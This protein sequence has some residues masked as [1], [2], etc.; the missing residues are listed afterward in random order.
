MLFI[1]IIKNKYNFCKKKIFYKTFFKKNIKNFYKIIYIIIK[2][3]FNK[4]KKNKFDKNKNKYFFKKILI[5]I[6]LLW[7]ISGFFIVKETE[8]A[9]ILRLGKFY[10]INCSGL[11][12]K[13]TFIDTVIIANIKSL[14][15]IKISD[16]ILTYD[17]NLI[18]IKVNIQYYINDL[19]NYLFNVANIEKSLK[20]TSYSAIRSILAKYNIFNILKKNSIIIQNKI[21][22]KIKKIIKPYNMGISVINVFFIEK[23]IPKKINKSF[24]KAINS[25]EK[26]NKYINQVRKIFYKEKIKTKEKAKNILEKVKNYKKKEILK[27]KIEI[28]KFIKILPEYNKFPYLTKKRIY[29]D[30]IEKILSNNNKIFIH[31]SLKNDIF[32][33]PSKILLNKN[34]NINFIKNICNKKNK[35]ILFFN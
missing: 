23:N 8:K 13:I 20:N 22:F 28:I 21:L 24:N 1:K 33:L 30:T 31:K 18:N 12:W 32:I 4:N 3:F 11:N 19:K 10:N 7:I 6:F 26:K 2:N 27:A 9:I 17:K 25:F 14:N 15:T 16:K 35:N 34:L 29:I 5:S